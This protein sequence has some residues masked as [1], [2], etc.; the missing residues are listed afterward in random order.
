[1]INPSFLCYSFFKNVKRNIRTMSMP[2]ILSRYTI[3]QFLT[4]FFAVMLT[5]GFVIVLFDVIELMKKGTTKISFGFGDVLIMALLKLP[6]MLQTLLPFAVLIGAIIVFWRLTKSHE[7]VIIRSAGQSVWQFIAP[8]MV[9]A[10]IL[11]VLNVTVFNP[12]SAAMFAKYQRLEDKKSD[13]PTISFQ[14]LWLREHRDDKMYV[15]HADA[16]RQDKYL[17]TLRIVSIFEFSDKD[18]FLRRIDADTALLVDGFFVLTDARIYVKGKNIENHKDL[19]FPTS[20]TLGKI[21]ENF[22]SPETISFW[23]LP[24]LIR[25]FESTGFSAHSHRLHLQ[26]LI[27][28]PF[29]LVTMILIAAVFS[30]N[31]NQRQGGSLLRISLGIAI[32]FLLY[33]MTR[34]T[35]ALG[36]ST[37]LPSAFAIWSPIVIFASLMTA[38]LLHQED[39]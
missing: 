8:L 25:F 6:N 7:L 4:S 23:D 39:G 38:I 5:L 27:A 13:S 24:D 19:M 22:A 18:E 14:G 3:R 30:I 34:I 37:A 29:L 17:L 20:L 9:T 26:S 36:F 1:M 16:I 31:P 28:S 15:V 11:G 2:R 12:F 21:Q 32:G 33:F 10:F 35:Y